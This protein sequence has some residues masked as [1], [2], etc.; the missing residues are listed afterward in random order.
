MQDLSA[1]TRDQTCALCMGRE[2][3]EVQVLE[4]LALAYDPHN[5]SKEQGPNSGEVGRWGMRVCPLMSNL[6]QPWEPL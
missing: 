4:P 6:V 1:L 2:E 5:S 3:T